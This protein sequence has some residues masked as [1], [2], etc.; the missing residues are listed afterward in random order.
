MYD[1][2]HYG[3]L[4]YTHHP[5]HMWCPKGWVKATGSMSVLMEDL[6]TDAPPPKTED[7]HEDD[8]LYAKSHFTKVTHNKSH[9]ARTT[10]RQS[11]ATKT[12]HHK[13][14]SAKSTHIRPGEPDE[15]PESVSDGDAV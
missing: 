12:T 6:P 8:A 1:H 15:E 5:T 7:D 4:D 14:H 9:A 11:H 13:G 10:H 2:G 3:W